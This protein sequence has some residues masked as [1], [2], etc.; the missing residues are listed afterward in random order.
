MSASKPSFIGFA[1]LL[2]LVRRPS[3]R[4]LRPWLGAQPSVQHSPIL[5]RYNEPKEQT[6]TSKIRLFTIGHST[7]PLELFLPLLAQHGIEALVDIRRFPGSRKFP[8]FNQDDL[9]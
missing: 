3:N 7:H 5:R 4:S 6:M 2:L 9:A 1:R 8:H